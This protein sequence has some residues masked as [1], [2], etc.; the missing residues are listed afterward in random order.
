MAT[1]Y[2]RA[3]PKQ[4]AWP[5]NALPDLSSASMLAGDMFLPPLL[6]ISSFLRSMIVR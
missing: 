6:M 5:I 1:L 2:G 4:T 3:S